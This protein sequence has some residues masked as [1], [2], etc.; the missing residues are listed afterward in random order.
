MHKES[1]Y[2]K[3]RGLLIPRSYV[4]IIDLYQLESQKQLTGFTAD[5]IA[6]HFSGKGIVTQVQKPFKMFFFIRLYESFHSMFLFVREL[7]CL[8]FVLG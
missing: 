7:G 3:Q 4:N 2:H 5:P 8:F 6:R 1:V